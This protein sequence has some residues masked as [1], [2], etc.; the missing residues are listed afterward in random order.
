[1]F[2]AVPTKVNSFLLAFAVLFSQSNCSASVSQLIFFIA[3]LFKFHFCSINLCSER[4]WT[5]R[6]RDVKWQHSAV[7]SVRGESK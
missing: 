1:M 7:V 2:D 4:P 3:D 5:L 6:V